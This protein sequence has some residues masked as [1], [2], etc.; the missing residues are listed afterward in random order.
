M[1]SP[2][3]LCGISAQ[4]PRASARRAG[5]RKG[6]PMRGF[7]IPCSLPRL[8]WWFAV[9]R[10][11]AESVGATFAKPANDN[12]LRLSAWNPPAPPST[13]SAA[14]SRAYESRRPITEAE[15]TA[16]GETK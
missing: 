2:G 12:A 11:Y 8:R 6:R 5:L 9:Q 15:S 14:P 4:T 3:P 16:S 1:T 10:I 13:F 7:S